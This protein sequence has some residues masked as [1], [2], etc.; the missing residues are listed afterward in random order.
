MARDGDSNLYINTIC[1]LVEVL[2]GEEREGGGEHEG[3]GSVRDDASPALI[4][5]YT[6]NH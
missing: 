6:R 4:R 5:N 1:A 2:R 3:G